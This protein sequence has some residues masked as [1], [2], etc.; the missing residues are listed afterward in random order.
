MQSDVPVVRPSTGARLI[1]RVL[2]AYP[3]DVI[4]AGNSVTF[5]VNKNAH[6]YS[7]FDL[8]VAEDR[9]PDVVDYLLSVIGDPLLERGTGKNDYYLDRMVVTEAS[10]Y[11]MHNNEFRSK[12]VRSGGY[13]AVIDAIRASGGEDEPTEGVRDAIF[14]TSYAEMEREVRRCLPQF[15]DGDVKPEV[16]KLRNRSNRIKIDVV[17][18]NCLIGNNA[19]RAFARASKNKDGFLKSRADA[20]YRLLSSFDLNLSQSAI[21]CVPPNSMHVDDY[22]KTFTMRGNSMNDLLAGMRHE[23]R[24]GSGHD[25]TFMTYSMCHQDSKLS[26]PDTAIATANTIKRATKYVRDYGYEEGQVYDEIVANILNQDAPVRDVIR[27][28]SKRFVERNGDVDYIPLLSV[29][30]RRNRLNGAL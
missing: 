27:E 24:K 26:V 30:M 25:A 16:F 3:D 17:N 22:I 2:E 10:F 15:V 23:P 12:R 14:A 4:W 18:M 11:Y 21:V 28:F 6:G 9:I 19:V 7:D 29:Y 20:V 13:S 1:F 8:F 5:M